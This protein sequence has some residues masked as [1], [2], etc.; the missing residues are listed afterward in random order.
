MQ[1]VHNKD[2]MQDKDLDKVAV[3]DLAELHHQPLHTEIKV[4]HHV[5][6]KVPEDR[7][8]LDKVADSAHHV[9]AKVHVLVPVA[10]HGK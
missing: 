7:K 4:E 1:L 6:A 8:D 3:E 9:L 10:L 2:L 5:L